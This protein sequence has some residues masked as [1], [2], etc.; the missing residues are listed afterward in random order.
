MMRRSPLAAFILLAYGGAWILWIPRALAPALGGG[1]FAPI[2][3]CIGSLAPALAALLVTALHARGGG[4]R[5][6]TSRIGQWR[7][8]LRWWTMALFG[9]VLLLAIGATAQRLA[10]DTDL[11]LSLVFRNAEYPHVPPVALI[12]LQIVCYGFGEEIG[13]RGFLH[14]ELR[15]RLRGRYSSLTAPLAVSVVWAGWHLPLLL[16]N[17][18]YRSFDAP[19]LLGWYASMLT[20]AV[21]MAWLFERSG[22]SIPVVAVFHG[23]L[24]VVMVN[25]AVEQPAMAA[26]GA[27]LTVWGLAAAGFVL[28]TR[29]H[30]TPTPVAAGLDR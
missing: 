8:P 30:E 1:R 4:V 26:M 18:T 27:A 21:L 24:D 13:W 22:R 12:V 28:R 5:A 25:R 10:L 6:L 11:D 23:L 16:A 20:G 2:A 29:Q 14:V 3:H 15:S 17:A 7:A 19:M 9:P